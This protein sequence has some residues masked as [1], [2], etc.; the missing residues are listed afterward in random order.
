VLGSDA[1][2]ETVR[3]RLAT[4]QFDFALRFRKAQ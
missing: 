3:R 4:G 1:D 2:V